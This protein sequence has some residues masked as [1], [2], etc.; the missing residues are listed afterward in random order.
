MKK[1]RLGIMEKVIAKIWLVIPFFLWGC[2]HW[3]S[4]PDVSRL[5]ILQGLTTKTMAQFSIVSSRDKE[6]KVTAEGGGAVIL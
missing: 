2:A 5:S 6:L 4:K 1:M 3:S